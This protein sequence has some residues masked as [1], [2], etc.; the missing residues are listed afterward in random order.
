MGYFILNIVHEQKEQ[1]QSSDEACTECRHGGLMPVV[2][3]EAEKD[4]CAFDSAG[5]TE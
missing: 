1:L 3:G 2:P 5:A 4:H